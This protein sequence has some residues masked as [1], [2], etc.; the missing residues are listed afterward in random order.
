VLCKVRRVRIHLHLLRL[1]HWF[2][3]WGSRRQRG[4]G[5]QEG[6]GGL[7]FRTHT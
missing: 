2:K 1:R 6:V 4:K 3:V 7:R 5:K